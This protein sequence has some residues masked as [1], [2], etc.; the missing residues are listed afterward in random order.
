MNHF[1]IIKKQLE[2][3]ALFDATGFTRAAIHALSEIEEAV[4]DVLYWRDELWKNVL[5]KEA[6]DN[7]IDVDGVIDRDIRYLFTDPAD[8]YCADCDSECQ[9]KH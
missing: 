9:G 7:L 8:A 4:G 6:W 3:K 5:N 2:D 1:D